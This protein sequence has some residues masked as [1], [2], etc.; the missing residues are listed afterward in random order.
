MLENIKNFDKDDGTPLLNML[1]LSNNVC[2]TDLEIILTKACATGIKL[3]HSPLLQ[4][5]INGTM[6]SI[7]SKFEDSSL[8]SEFMT[9]CK[10]KN[11]NFHDIFNSFIDNEN[12]FCMFKEFSEI[13]SFENLIKM[14]FCTKMLM[15]AIKKGNQNLI[16]S[17]IEVFD[18]SMDLRVLVECF[19][20]A[21]DFNQTL[22]VDFILAKVKHEN[23]NCVEAFKDACAFGQEDVVAVM[24]DK[25]KIID[26]CS[27]DFLL[28]LT[29]LKNSSFK[30]RT[31]ID[32][33]IERIVQH[34][35][36]EKTL[37][38]ENLDSILDFSKCDENILVFPVKIEQK[39]SDIKTFKFVLVKQKEL[40][41]DV[42][43]VETSKD[44]SVL[45]DILFEKK[46]N[47]VD[48]PSKC[49]SL[50][51]LKKDYIQRTLKK[52]ILHSKLDDAE[53]NKLEELLLDSMKTVNT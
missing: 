12:V 44:E 19:R 38:K 40:S 43:N 4:K 23:L 14:V 52:V 25:C 41:A 1:R 16:K 10:S 15:T 45:I 8:K 13:S 50:Q 46:M 30:K 11:I 34:C 32:K 42:L 26:D 22:L 5:H 21:I 9:I 7:V 37:G 29:Q 18:D 35:Y 3:L 33:I 31:R 48:I 2:E 6:F 39:V 17:I 20:P 27:F 36:C 49:S 24:L 53:R 47:I 51:E 28:S